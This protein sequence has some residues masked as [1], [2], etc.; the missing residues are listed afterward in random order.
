MFYINRVFYDAQFFEYHYLKKKKNL[1]FRIKSTL[2]L[3]TIIQ[4]TLIYDNYIP[5]DFFCKYSTY[6]MIILSAHLITIIQYDKKV[7]LST[8]FNVFP[9]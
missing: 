1:K 4:F 6:T 5:V 9:A 2:L 3:E 7:I 8:L